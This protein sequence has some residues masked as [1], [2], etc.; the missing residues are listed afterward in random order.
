M[1]DVDTREPSH[2]SVT[3]NHKLGRTA[4]SPSKC[5]SGP[6][7]EPDVQKPLAANFAEVAKAWL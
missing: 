6:K 1:E 5:Q 7:K 3:N 2:F 4:A